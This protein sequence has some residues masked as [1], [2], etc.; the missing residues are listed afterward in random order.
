MGLVGV[1]DLVVSTGDVFDCFDHLV[2]DRNEL[3][4]DRLKRLLENDFGLFN[5]EL[6]SQES[7]LKGL[8]RTIGSSN[9]LLRK[10]VDSIFFL[11]PTEEIHILVDRVC[12]KFTCLVAH[13]SGN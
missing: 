2:D 8:I 11:E 3:I 1:S 10:G 4:L 13:Q 5:L 6:Q 7:F 12:G 9:D